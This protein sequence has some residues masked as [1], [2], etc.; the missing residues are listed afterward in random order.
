[1]SSPA[2]LRLHHLGVVVDDVDAAAAAYV[3]AFGAIDE[4][5]TFEDPLQLA[6]IRFLR[7]GDSRVELLAPLRDDSHLKRL[8]GRGIGLYHA[9]YEVGDVAGELERMR[10]GGAM[11][12]SPPK[13]AVAF[14]GRPVAFVICRGLLIE[15]LQRDVA[16]PPAP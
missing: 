5:T 16:A 9:C 7:L 14:G 6:R 11:I 15:L 12:V 8:A 1:M 3:Q 2:G 4:G 13:P 10:G